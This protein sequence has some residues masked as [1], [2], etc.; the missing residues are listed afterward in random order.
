MTN[1]QLGLCITTHPRAAI[2]TRSSLREHPGAG[3]HPPGLWIERGHVREGG[4]GL[5]PSQWKA[6]GWNKT[7][8]E[9]T[10]MTNGSCVRGT[11][12]CIY[13]NVGSGSG[14][15]PPAFCMTLELLLTK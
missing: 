11:R 8:H 15:A 4:T 14:A 13:E 7:G 5:A 10:N 1:T 12:V 6:D 2:R 3:T 9:E